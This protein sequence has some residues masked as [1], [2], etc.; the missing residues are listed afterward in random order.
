MHEQRHIKPV[1]WSRTQLPES[2]EG[3]ACVCACMLGEGGKL[4]GDRVVCSLR[5]PGRCAVWQ[6][7]EA[8]RPQDT[9]CMPA[10][11]GAASRADRSGS[12]PLTFL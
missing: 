5:E 7:P 2:E 4:A 12:H 3:V 6:P 8:P 11:G 9:H 1:H 10:R